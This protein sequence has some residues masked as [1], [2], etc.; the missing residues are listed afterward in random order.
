MKN[1]PKGRFFIG[2]QACASAR[3]NRWRSTSP[4]HSGGDREPIV[5]GANSNVLDGLASRPGS[6]RST[7]WGRL[8]IRNSLVVDTRSR[9]AEEGAV[10]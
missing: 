7:N 10:A 8:E 9:A 2:A 6:A 5:I 3:D 1:R 4:D